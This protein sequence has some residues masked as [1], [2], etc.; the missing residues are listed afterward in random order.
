MSNA[1]GADAPVDQYLIGS[2]A[3]LKNGPSLE[4]ERSLLTTHEQMVKHY[5]DNYVSMMQKKQPANKTEPCTIT[6]DALDRVLNQILWCSG[7]VTAPMAKQM[8]LVEP[9]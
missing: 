2:S 3:I 4:V 7:K 5:A 1:K 6:A 8:A 9:M